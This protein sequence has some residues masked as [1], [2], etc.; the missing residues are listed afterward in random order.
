M[1]G[2]MNVAGVSRLAF[3]LLATQHRWSVSDEVS[4]KSD[5][6]GREIIVCSPFMDLD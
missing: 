1:I 3:D 2:G 6:L 5:F 4:D